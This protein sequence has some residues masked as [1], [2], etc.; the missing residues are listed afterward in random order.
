MLKPKSHCPFRL[1]LAAAFAFSLSLGGNANAKMFDINGTTSGFGVADA[2]SYDWLGTD[3]WN[4]ATDATGDDGTAATATWTSGSSAFFV[5]AGAGT[6]YTVRLGST[7]ASNTN[8]ANLAI[9][10]TANGNGA[11]S[12]A[13]G[14]VTIGNSGDAGILTLSSSNSVG[15]QGGGTLTINNGM[16]LN[17]ATMNFRGGNVVIN[18]VV[19]GTGASKI[20][21]GGGYGLTSGTLTLA[22]TANTYAGRANSD[23]ITTNYTL[24]VTKLANGG[25]NS[26]I[27]ISSANIGING[28]TLKYIGSTGAQS[29][30]LGL[31][32]ASGGAFIDASGSTS[33]DTISISGAPTYSATNSARAI[34]LTGTNSGTNT[35]GFVYE[36]NGS[37][38]NTLTKNGTGTWVITQNN[39]FTGAV[40]VT[41]GTLRVTH[42]ASLG[43]GT[44]NVSVTGNTWLELDGSGGNLSFASGVTFRVSGNEAYGIKNLAGNN[45]I[46]GGLS[47]TSGFGNSTVVSTGGSL[48]LAGTVQAIVAGGRTLMLNGTTAGNLIS[49]QI[50]NG[51]SAMSITKDGVGT[52]EISNANT[53]TGNT[54]VAGGTLKLTNNLAIQNSPFDTSG[55]GTL[56]VTTINTPTFGGLTSGTNYA[57]PSNVTSLTLNNAT[58]GAL[59]YSGNLTAGNSAMTLT[60]QGANSQTLS[61]TNSYNGLTKVTGNSILF[62]GNAGAIG[63]GAVQVDSGSRLGLQGGIILGSGRTMTISGDGGLGSNTSLWGALRSISANTNEW[64]GNVTLGAVGTRIGAEA[65]TL[66][67]SGVIS[68]TNTGLFIRGNGAGTSVDLSGANNYTGDTT[69]ASATGGVVTLSGGANRLPTGTKLIMGFTTVSSKLDLNGQNQEVAGISVGQTSGTISNEITSSTGTPTFTVNT[70]AASSYNGTITGSIVLT[71]QGAD[72]LTLTGNNTYTGGTTLNAGTLSVNRT[73][74]LGASSG[75]L[76]FGGN[77]T[78]ATTADITSSRNYTINSDV[79]ATID[80]A[81]FTTLSNNAVISGSGALMKA[82]TGNLTLT[83][84]NTYTGNTTVGNGNLTVSGAG[85]LANTSNVIITNG[86]SLLVS[87]SNAI[88][89]SANVTMS[90]GNLTMAIAAADGNQTLGALTLSANSTLDFSSS[91]ANTLRFSGINSPGTNVFN[92]INWTSLSDHLF[93]TSNSSLSADN[94]TFNGLANSAFVNNT[95]SGYEIIPVPEPGTIVAGTLLLGG[96]AFAERR[97]MKRWLDSLMS[98]GRR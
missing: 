11:L 82:G 67:V 72:T 14:N 48:T 50:I 57:L 3:L 92:I 76:T 89:T 23:Y 69:I 96:L 24:A 65:G 27:G 41:D 49:G 43:S 7:G 58:G 10:V 59:T 61:G 83:G 29:T 31:H 35:M 80:T 22:N 85:R 1:S 18:G 63:S 64:A 70:A 12:G 75:N 62:V 81:S 17:A 51:T 46:N 30:N 84:V 21:F 87:S 5:G 56:D 37:G 77:S 68:G 91:S 71:K 25:S 15:A 32:I 90:G 47:L 28:G 19:S 45:T 52:W 88:N 55:A 66:K 34:T 79:V 54:K 39:S 13:A 74:S 94:F 93:F 98:V 2:G 6:N 20:A 60:K 38:V 26:S 42:S 86:G 78:L 95:G 9:N 8:I 4:S 44:K 36:D 40:N 97:R 53:F 33:S 73:E 16:N